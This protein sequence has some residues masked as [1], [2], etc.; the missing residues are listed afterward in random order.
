MSSYIFFVRTFLHNNVEAKKSQI[1]RHVENLLRLV[2]TRKHLFKYSIQWQWLVRVE[3]CL[4]D[5]TNVANSFPG[6]EGG[7]WER[8]CECRYTLTL[9]HLLEKQL[10]YF[11]VIINN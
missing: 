3:H 10:L 2:T 6:P 7:P 4:M 8:G 9:V 5:T 11:D 1:W